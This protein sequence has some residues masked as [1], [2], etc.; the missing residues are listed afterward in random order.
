MVMPKCMYLF[1][2]G[3]KAR[4]GTIPQTAPCL[5]QPGRTP[6]LHRL[7]KVTRS[8]RSILL[9]W[10][11]I[12]DHRPGSTTQ[13]KQVLSILDSFLKVILN[14]PAV[15]TEVKS[16][17]VMLSSAA[18]WILHHSTQ[19]FMRS[20]FGICR[21]HLSNEMAKAGE[22]RDFYPGKKYTSQCPYWMYA[23]PSLALCNPH[24]SY[25]RV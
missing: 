14:D 21:I 22:C 13:P 20:Q 11:N 15:I 2:T 4:K 24:H 5:E 17:F 3:V 23:A 18:G 8:G 1:K 10:F 16:A 25:Q 19:S 6:A 9:V 7:G 12:G